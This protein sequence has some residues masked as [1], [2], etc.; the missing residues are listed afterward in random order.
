LTEVYQSMLKSL[1][2]YLFKKSA[3]DSF[4]AQQFQQMENYI[5]GVQIQI[6]AL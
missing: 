4:T 1:P 3:L 6:A 2:K 5:L